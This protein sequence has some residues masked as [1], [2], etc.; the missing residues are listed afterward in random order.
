MFEGGASG[1]QRV[2]DVE[3]RGAG[4]RGDA[5]ELRVERLAGLRGHQ[6]GDEGGPGGGRPVLGRRGLLGLGRLLDH[7]VGVGAADAEGGDPGTAGAAGLGPGGVLGEQADVARAPVDVAGGL[8]DVEGAGKDAVLDGEHGLDDA[9]DTGG[10]LGVPDVRLHRAE[11][12]RPV[13]G[14]VLPV[15]RQQRLRL[16]RVAQRGARPV[17]LHGVHVGGGEPG[18]RQGLAD[19]ALLGRAVGGGQAVGGTVLVDGRAAH[20]GQYL[21]A[22]AAGVGEPFQDEDAG[23]LGPAGPVGG[24][25]ERLAAAAGGDAALAGEAGEAHRG[26][27]HGD[28]AGQGEA[29][30]AVAQ[31]LGRQVDG[32]QRGG[33]GG[34]DG[35]GG[36][37]EVEGVRQAA[38]DHAGGEAGGGVALGVLP[39]VHDDADVVDAGRADVDAGAAAAQGDRVDARPLHRLPAGLQQDPLL[40]V[41]GDRLAGRDPEEARVEGGGVDEAALARRAA[42][43]AFA[44]QGVEVPAPVGGEGRDAVTALL[45]EPPV[46]LGGRDASGQP[47]GHADDRDG[48]AA[49][50]LRLLQPPTGLVQIGRDPLEVVDELLVIGHDVG[51]LPVVDQARLRGRPG[52]RA[53]CR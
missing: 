39:G 20:H 53:R 19:D 45:Q 32:D 9:R 8:V 34:V 7:D 26:G 14:P 49:V 23:A 43:G 28:A 47:A 33:A 13:L 29:A 24:V 36:P 10:G 21:V 15:R 3:R 18:A 27:H 52:G 5:G 30:L 48:F 46:L 25:G 1:G 42:A 50:G 41:H 2:T 22:V 44:V 31:R 17:C 6:P 35:D 40:R 37:G 16:D 12:Q 51:N 11:Q 4:D 38:G